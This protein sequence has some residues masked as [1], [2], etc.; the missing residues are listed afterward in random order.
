MCMNKYTINTGESAMK[1]PWEW[2]G[3]QQVTNVLG[4]GVM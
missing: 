4:I 3:H 1:L 2:N